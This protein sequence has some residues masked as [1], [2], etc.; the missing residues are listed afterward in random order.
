M[1]PLVLGS[2]VAAI[3]VGPPLYSLV[4]N[5]QMDGTSAV[6]RALLVAA[7]CAAGVGYVLKLVRGYE[8]ESE[9]KQKRE[10]LLQAIAEAEAAA[11][12]HA[13]AVTEAAE[14][15]DPPKPS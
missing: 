11:K 14:R 12:R 9:S 10:N 5:G 1:N 15:G 6:F 4:Q 2:A 13:D 7:V 8:E 3:L